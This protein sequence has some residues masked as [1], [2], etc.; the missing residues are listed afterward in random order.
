MLTGSA[1][2]KS[3]HKSAEGTGCATPQGP[4]KTQRGFKGEGRE[5]SEDEGEKAALGPLQGMQRGH[6]SGRQHLGACRR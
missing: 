4:A 5:E 6:S 2:R 3:A 1:K